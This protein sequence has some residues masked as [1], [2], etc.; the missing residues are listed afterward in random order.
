MAVTRR[1]SGGRSIG[2]FVVVFWFPGTRSKWLY[3]E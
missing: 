1:M 3:L 2:S